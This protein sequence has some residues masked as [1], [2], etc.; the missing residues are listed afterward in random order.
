[1]EKLELIG[2]EEIKLF[3]TKF[4]FFSKKSLNIFFDRALL[5]SAENF[6]QLMSERLE[7]RIQVTISR[8]IIAEP[9]WWFLILIG[10]IFPLNICTI[11]FFLSFLSRIY[12]WYLDKKMEKLINNK[13][14]ETMIYGNSDI[15]EEIRRELIKKYGYENL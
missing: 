11:F 15:L 12:L 4:C 10:L 14:M 5:K 13:E 3:P 8:R 9:L 7:E 1:M 6:R 2:I